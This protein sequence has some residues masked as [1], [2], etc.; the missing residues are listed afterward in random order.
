MRKRS[1]RF[2]VI[3]LHLVGVSHH[4]PTISRWQL[5]FLPNIPQTGIVGVQPWPIVL[6]TIHVQ[7]LPEL[8]ATEPVWLQDSTDKTCLGPTG[9]FTECGDA[10]LWFVVRVPNLPATKTGGERATKTRN[11]N[12]DSNEARQRRRD[13]LR[14]GVFGVEDDYNSEDAEAEEEEVV[15]S[16]QV[17]DRDF[18]DPEEQITAP[19]E[20]TKRP[21][22]RCGR[23]KPQPQPVVECLLTTPSASTSEGSDS[24]RAIQVDTCVLPHEDGGGKNKKGRSGSSPSSSSPSLVNAWAWKINQQG[25]LMS[26]AEASDGSGSEAESPE[27]QQQRCLWRANGSQAVLDDCSATEQDQRSMVNFS[28]VRYRAV[29]ATTSTGS[30]GSS[31][32]RSLPSLKDIQSPAALTATTTKLTA[33]DTAD[34]DSGDHLP[35]NKAM[36]NRAAS[37]H[38]PYAL[39]KDT[40]PIL[41]M[42]HA[43]LGGSGSRRR[44]TST[45]TTPALVSLLKDTNPILLMGQANRGYGGGSRRGEGLKTKSVGT[46]TKI[47]PV[48][49]AGSAED[50][51]IPPARM[52]VHPYIAASNNEVW[53]DPSTGLEYFT[54]LCHYLGRDRKEYGR[55][56]LTGVGQYR[57]GYV[58]KVYGI[59][60]YVSKNDILADKI[61]EPYAGLSAD[62]LRARPE[63]YE[64]LRQMPNIKQ[65]GLGIFDRTILL[66][67]NMQLSA[68]T[69]RSSLHADWKFLTDEAK[70][71]LISSSLEPRPANEEMLKTIASSENPSRCSCSQVA[72]E[73]YQADPSCCA[74]GTELGFTWL[75]SGHLEVSSI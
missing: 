53:K 14:R 75:K 4:L 52:H 22:W 2:F 3:L 64:I 32:G 72:P 47:H 57:K 40:N 8:A 37:E 34:E 6:E 62:E 67:I 43:N 13:Q 66:K 15:W 1:S 74:R 41:L 60:H 29:S 12:S 51:Y 5:P 23:Q 28:V 20:T 58:V 73:E 44:D 68:E 70:T 59:A 10:T 17:V 49:K 9:K 24:S 42:G 30:S 48:S 36:A 26:L 63:F 55:H 38:L 33:L 71:T 16:F 21:W 45:T 35:S 54:D 46:T 18:P 69:M 19:V 39:L 31:D 25:V 11:D 27:Q 7:E 56:T 65:P 50:S 61:F